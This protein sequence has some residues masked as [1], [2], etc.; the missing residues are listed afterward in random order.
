M[1]SAHLPAEVTVRY[2]AGARAVAGIVSETVAAGSV[3][4]VLEAV[5]TRHTGLAPVLA[6]ASFL[7]DGVAS[8][9]DAAVPPGATLDILPPF[10]G[11]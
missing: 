4:E 6:V 9:R 11:G 1:P 10:A 2:W 3:G 8:D 7:V 5:R